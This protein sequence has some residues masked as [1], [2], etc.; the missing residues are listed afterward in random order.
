MKNVRN[1]FS[2]NYDIKVFHEYDAIV[3][4]NV[5]LGRMSRVSNGLVTITMLGFEIIF[6]ETTF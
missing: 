2:N 1:H 6:K 3:Q 4:K 5:K